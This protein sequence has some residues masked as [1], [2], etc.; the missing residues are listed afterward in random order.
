MKT[1]PAAACTYRPNRVDHADR[2]LGKLTLICSFLVLPLVFMLFAQWP[3]REL[4][5]AWSRQANDLGQ[6][7][8]AFYVAVA[9]TAA[10]RGHT[11]LASSRPLQP[12]ARPQKW[13][14][15]AV[16][17]CTAP[18]ALFMLWAGWPLVVSSVLAFERFGDTNTPGYFLVKVSL[19]LMLLM[20][21]LDGLVQI[22]RG[23][24]EK[25]PPK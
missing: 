8:F 18:W 16:F 12:G 22:V 5:Q 17:A 9:I 3:L 7:L 21:L 2:L 13:Q 14:A 25:K 1:S 10:S 20:V 23:Q 6:I 4:F 11:H 19:I 15:W 24:G